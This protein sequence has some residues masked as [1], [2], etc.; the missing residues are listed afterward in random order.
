MST[1]PLRAPPSAYPPRREPARTCPIPSAISPAA[2]KAVDDLFRPRAPGNVL[3][4]RLRE[5]IHSLD[6]KMA[7]LMSQRRD[8]E[9]RLEQAVR[10]QSPVL[11]LPSELLASIFIIGVLGDKEDDNSESTDEE[12]MTVML[13]ALMLVCRY[14]LEVAL[15]T[16]LL[17]AKIAVSP[18]HSLEKARCKLGRSKSCP[19]DISINFGPRT[20]YTSSVT[21]QVVHAM[22]LFRPAL[23]RIKSF[24]L[25]VPN[26]PQAHAVLLRCQEDAPLLE[27]LSIRI[28]HAMQDD[29][30]SVAPLPLFNG[31]TP[32]LRSCSLTSFNFGWNLQLVS[33]LRVLKLGGYFNTHTPSTNTLLGI[34]RECPQLEEL[35]LRNLSDVDCAPCFSSSE[36]FEFPVLTKIVHLPRLKKASFYYAGIALT[37]QLMAQFTFPNL[38]SLE[39][40][41]LENVTPVLQLVYTQA[42]TRLPLRHLRIES[43]LFN[44]LK[45]VNLLRRLPSLVRLELVDVEDASSGL[46][47]VRGF[48]IYSS[49]QLADPL[50]Q[51]LSSSQPWACP[52]L[53]SLT[54]DGCTSLDWDSLRTFVE[55]RLPANSHAYP[56][57]QGVQPFRSSHP[58]ITS[59]SAA[60]AAHERSRSHPSPRKPH[61]IVFLGPLRLRA[62]DVTR[63]T[64]ISKEMVQ[65]LRMYVAEVKCERA[66]GVWGE[67]MP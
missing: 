66:K 25:S 18:H 52:K 23:W 28:Y 65:W 54:L 35:A 8:L 39:L 19:L 12:D 16:P 5:A 47:R 24:R 61:P 3:I 31:R 46:L 10:L 36:E 1:Y 63:C 11:R 64:Q 59:A 7:S 60:A 22:D 26:R 50:P 29:N 4:P 51:G 33:R 15:S 38:E 40:C 34:L 32:R 9:S 37:Q 42:L 57:F 58:P 67:P 30:Y 43:S 45:L 17:W 6:S 14:W 53:E 49:V 48:V 41:Y 27:V 21:E 44:E 20:E 62:I 13:P 2:L 55:S 56:R